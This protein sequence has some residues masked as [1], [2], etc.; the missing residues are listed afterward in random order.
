MLLKSRIVVTLRSW[1]PERIPEIA[2]AFGLTD[3]GRRLPAI[4]LCTLLVPE[5]VDPDAALAGVIH[6]PEVES[7]RFD[8]K[9]T[10]TAVAAGNDALLDQAWHLKRMHVYDAWE[11]TTGAGAHS[12]TADSGLSDYGPLGAPIADRLHEDLPAPAWSMHTQTGPAVDAWVGGGHGENVASCIHAKRNNGFGSAGVAPDSVFGIAVNAW[13]DGPTAEDFV[14]GLIYAAEQGAHTHS[15]SVF[16]PAQANWTGPLE[17][18]V[19]YAKGLGCLTLAAAGNTGD[20]LDGMDGMP[21]RG[22]PGA[23]GYPA[24]LPDVVNVAACQQDD[25]LSDWPGSPLSGYG[26]GVDVV[27]PGTAI[28]VVEPGGRSAYGAASGTSFATP[29]ANGV[30]TLVKAANPHLTPADI[31]AVIR[32]TA[33]PS[34]H[35]GFAADFP[36]AGIAN[37]GKAVAKALSLLPPAEFDSRWSAKAGQRIFPFARF[38]RTNTPTGAWDMQSIVGGNRVLTLDGDVKIELSVYGGDT[39]ELWAGGVKLYDG[40][41]TTRAFT[42]SSAGTPIPVKIVGRTSTGGVWEVERTDVV[43]ASLAADVE[44]TTPPVVT[45]FTVPAAHDSLVVPVT[46]LTA[47]EDATFIV[48]ENGA[49]PTAGDGRWGVTPAMFTVG[50]AGLRTLY[51]W[52][53]DAA[54]NVSARAQTTVTVTLPDSQAPT[55][56]AFALPAAHTALAVPISQLTASEA[57]TWIL[58]E[59]GL[60]PVAGDARWGAA[61]ASFLV[62][63]EG[64]RTV[65]A[66]AR[67]GVGNVSARAQATVTVTLSVEEPPVDPVSPSLLKKPD[68]TGAK[69][70]HWNGAEWVE[71]PLTKV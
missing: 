45:A 51:A 8:V 14:A 16:M 6:R 43:V 66:W 62:G 40:P 9:M 58:S 22:V 64:L 21:I 35:P 26:P 4:R 32:E 15:L 49:T 61:P 39:V 71:V 3:S 41:P 23:F 10:R 60:D 65:Y 38:F 17:D 13:E 63:G 55:V 29:L 53:K 52:A 7:A 33:D 50:G 70:K 1:E 59:S 30:A 67:D 28:M 36:N 31:L 34:Q 20:Y 2:A 54:G 56:T 44:D 69:L 68:G 47:D 57:S 42:A 19:Q 18:A 11:W 25:D 5:G 46:T 27:A 48:S 37:A 12:S 24:E